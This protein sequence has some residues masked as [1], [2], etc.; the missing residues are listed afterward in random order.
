MQEDYFTLGGPIILDS[1]PTDAVDTEDAGV[2]NEDGSE[3]DLPS[4]FIPN[5]LRD[6]VIAVDENFFCTGALPPHLLT[7]TSINLAEGHFF[8]EM[9]SDEPF[10]YTGVR[11]YGFRCYFYH[12][13]Y[14]SADLAV[15]I[16]LPYPSVLSDEETQ[17]ALRDE[18]CHANDMAALLV[19][20]VEK[21]PVLLDTHPEARL[22]LT[23]DQTGFNYGFYQDG[24]QLDV[25]E[26]PEMLVNILNNMFPADL[27]YYMTMIR[28]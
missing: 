2:D 24:H 6:A 26:N 14:Q 19:A 22:R 10:F 7:E 12:W 9:P 25:A 17:Q 23:W 28:P 18:I 1:L 27:M 21:N 15:S 20:A 5:A 13:F 3:L 11:G 8:E 16:V 4:L